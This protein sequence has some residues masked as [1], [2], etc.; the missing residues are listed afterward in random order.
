MRSAALTSAVPLSTTTAL[1]S[2]RNCSL[3]TPMT[4]ASFTAG[5]AS[6]Q[7]STSAGKMF[8][9]PDLIIRVIVPRKVIV[10]SGL[11]R[12]EVGWCQPAGRGSARALTSGPVPVAQGG[13]G[14]AADA[15][16]RQACAGWR[17]PRP[18]APRIRTEVTG[19]GRPALPA[20]RPPYAAEQAEA[21]DLGLSVAVAHAAAFAAVA[22]VVRR[23][24]AL[25]QRGRRD[26]GLQ[27]RQFRCRARA[28]ARPAG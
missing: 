1:T 22:A 15:G 10:P 17:T 9:A 3:G 12:A 23:R 14:A 6:R 13:A 19:A 25:P 27:V 18:P 7:F 26:G 8:S 16:L 2:C 5:W 4:A 20:P 11:A 21:G 24:Q 28:S